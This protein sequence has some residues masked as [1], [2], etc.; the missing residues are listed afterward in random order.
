VP[1]PV[2]VPDKRKNAPAF[3]RRVLID[4][5]CGPAEQNFIVR[6]RVGPHQEALETLISGLFH[7][8]KCSVRL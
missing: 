4:D 3:A 1:V 6:R 8:R 5:A 7:V 2:P